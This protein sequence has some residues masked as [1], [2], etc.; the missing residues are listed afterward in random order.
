LLRTELTLERND[1]LVAAARVEVEGFETS[2]ATISDCFR[3]H[4]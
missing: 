4:N 1:A 2:I 3:E